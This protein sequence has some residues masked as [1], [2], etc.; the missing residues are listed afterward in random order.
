MFVV[1]I[2]YTSAQSLSEELTI[3]KSLGDLCRELKTPEWVSAVSLGTVIIF[4]ILVEELTKYL[5]K[6]K[7]I[8]S[9][10]RINDVL[11][12]GGNGLSFSLVRHWLILQSVFLRFN[13]HEDS[14]TLI[15]ETQPTFWGRISPQS[16]SDLRYLF[17]MFPPLCWMYLDIAKGR[18]LSEATVNREAWKEFQKKVEARFLTVI[19]APPIV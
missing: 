12:T 18:T 4:L 19:S 5:A 7:A 15:V 16:G 3:I 10:G 9:R 11:N 13:L 14:V 1:L 2:L 6:T 17:G 8:G